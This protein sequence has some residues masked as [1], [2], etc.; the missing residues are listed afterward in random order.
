MNLDIILS[1]NKSSI[2]IPPYNTFLYRCTLTENRNRRQTPLHSRRKIS[3]DL[4]HCDD[5]KTLHNST[6]SLLD[7]IKFCR[8]FEETRLD[9]FRITVSFV[10]K[11]ST[12]TRALFT[13]N[14]IRN[15][16]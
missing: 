2:L 12:F 5:R 11:F 7:N 8:S 16:C 13:R 14:R 4:D 1:T 3:R 6:P 10:W 15:Q 9:S